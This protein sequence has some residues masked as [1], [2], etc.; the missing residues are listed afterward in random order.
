MSK[1]LQ[2]EKGAPDINVVR[3]AKDALAYWLHTKHGIISSH[4]ASAVTS[5]EH[6]GKEVPPWASVLAEW[7][8]DWEHEN[9]RVH[10]GAEVRC[11]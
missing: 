11:G 8:M 10:D 3:A 9:T 5:A 7:I 2:Q 6:E 4:T 1:Q